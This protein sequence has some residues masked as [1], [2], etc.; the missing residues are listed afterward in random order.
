MRSFRILFVFFLLFFFWSTTF[1]LFSATDFITQFQAQQNN[2]SSSAKLSYYK[3]VLANL[4]LLMLR[5]RDD[6]EQVKLYTALERYVTTQ[7]ENLWPTTAAVVSFALVPSVPQMSIPNVDFERVRAAWLSWH[8]TERATKSLTPFTYNS[9]LEWTATTWA[10][11]L[12]DIRVA[13]HKR[14][15]TDRYYSY[16]SIKAWFLDQWIVF[17]W[18][19]VFTE[20]IWWNFYSCKK[21]DCTDDFIK[22]IKKSRTFFMSEKGKRYRPHYNAIMWNFSDIGLG[23]ALVG[24][25]YY[26]VSHY[27]TALQ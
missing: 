15:S 7:I 10:D 25:K 24:N 18:E 26:L 23:V 9:A 12:A 27:T 3:K 14:K 21:T 4:R 2:L 16:A 11:H 8:N 6:A 19:A 1:A 5:N 22:A 13:S 20:N 17:S